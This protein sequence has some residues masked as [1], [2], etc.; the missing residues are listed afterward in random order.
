MIAALMPTPPFRGFFLNLDRSQARLD[1]MNAQ[2]AAVGMS[3]AYQR[4]PAVDGPSLGPEY[5]T[6]LDRGNLGLWITHER[7]IEANRSSDSHLHILEDDSQLPKDAAQSLPAML[8]QA[9]KT[10][11]AWDLIFTEVYLHMGISIF[12]LVSKAKEA[13]HQTHQPVLAPLKQIPF[14]GTSSVFVNKRSLEKYLRL[15]SGQ[16][17]QGLPLD[18]YL[19]S[20]INA[21]SLNALV[22]L[23][24]L[25]TLS[26]NTAQSEIQNAPLNQSHLV[27]NIYRRSVFKDADEAALNNEIDRLSNDVTVP[28]LTEIYL[29]VLRY[30]LS[31]NHVE[32]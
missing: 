3:Q 9:D 15:L 18:L 27:L 22:T 7:L 5:Q 12:R 23:P 21:G 1:S 2:L 28:G 30:C 24:F 26:E 4:V 13:F 32:I 31:D 11:P 6:N 8:Q 29:K 17:K 20:L 16:W 19:R 25:T 14:A 10:H